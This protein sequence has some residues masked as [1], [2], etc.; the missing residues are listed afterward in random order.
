MRGGEL[1]TV[2]CSESLLVFLPRATDKKK[3]WI[4][5]PT[6]KDSDFGLQVGTRLTA[7]LCFPRGSVL[8]S[9]SGTECIL[10]IFL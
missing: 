9:S 5:L 7:M 8:P 2:N 3:S 10:N 1:V 6:V 4:S